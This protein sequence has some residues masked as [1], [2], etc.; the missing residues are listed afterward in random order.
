[1]GSNSPH[2]SGPDSLAKGDGRL[3]SV[4]SDAR[5]RLDD[6]EAA[7]PKAAALAGRASV[8]STSCTIPFRKEMMSFVC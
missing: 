7:P 4:S 1:M 5:R 6:A 2:G 8:D 3:S